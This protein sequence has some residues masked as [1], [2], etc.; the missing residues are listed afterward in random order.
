MRQLLIAILLAGVLGACVPTA[1]PVA[2]VPTSSLEA[3]PESAEGAIATPESLDRLFE[4]S[5]EYVAARSSL[6]ER[7]IAPV[8]ADR[9]VVAALEAVP[10]HSFVPT[11]GL[12]L[13][14]RDYPLPIGYGQTISQPS[15]V[16]LM[17]EQLEL[18]PGDRVLEIGTGSGYQA[19]ILREM[20]DEV[21]SVEI[22]PELAGIARA[23]LD[24]LGYTDIHLDRRDGYYGWSEHAPYDA[25]IVTAAPD[26]MPPTLTEQLAPDGGRMVIPIGPVGNVQTL[27]LVTRNGDDVQ[28]EQLLEVRFV[29]LT[30]AA[31]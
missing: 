20:T 27:W 8:V 23:V 5:E 9:R 10:R 16:A 31:D 12:D 19:A 24:R 30:R 7:A 26:H 13:A 4:D 29:P 3:A 22:I 6:V 1:E 18:T 21:Y 11:R 17:T 28:M 15:L 14:Y 25:I 2:S